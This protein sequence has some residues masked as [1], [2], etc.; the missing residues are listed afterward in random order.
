MDHEFEKTDSQNNGL[1]C[2]ISRNHTSSIDSGRMFAILESN[3]DLV[4]GAYQQIDDNVKKYYFGQ[5]KLN[6][7]R[8]RMTKKESLVSVVSAQSQEFVESD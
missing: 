2:Y 7:G 3:N 1:V 6:F 8:N 5:P 4:E